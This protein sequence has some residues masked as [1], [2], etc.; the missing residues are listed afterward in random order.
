MTTITRI[1]T[2]TFQETSKWQ[3]DME[4]WKDGEH[5]HVQLAIEAT[6]PDSP[7]YF[8]RIEVG[9]N[10]ETNKFVVVGF[11]SFGGGYHNPPDVDEW[12]PE[13]EFATMGEAVAFAE[14]KDTEFWNAQD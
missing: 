2:I 14:Q 1:G 11:R 6:T 3:W 5:Q 13:N 8:F 4:A 9:I 10:E 12:H 7:R